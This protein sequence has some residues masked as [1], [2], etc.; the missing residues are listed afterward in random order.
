MTTPG[1]LTTP[2][3]VAGAGVDVRKYGVILA[4]PPWK[5][6]NAGTRGAAENEYTTMC[7]LDLKA[8]PVAQLAAKD[9]LLACWC[10]W[11]MLEEGVDLLK[12]WE[13]EFITGF[14]WIKTQGDPQK[15]LFDNEWLLKPIYWVGYWMRGCS[16]F[17]LLARRGKPKLPEADFVG[18]LSQNFQ[19]SR[20]P[21]NL[22]EYCES[23]P[24][25]Y[26]ELFCRRPREGWDVFGNEI[27]STP[28]V[29]EALTQ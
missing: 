13:F 8:M 5:Y 19:H 27:E 26:L 6:R 14:P 18:L 15:S 28:A 25:P 2:P 10:T 4:D 20:K 21:E 24:G 12:A 16:E 23:V 3:A 29:L 1:N 9:C 11:P 7:D 22:Y 17:V